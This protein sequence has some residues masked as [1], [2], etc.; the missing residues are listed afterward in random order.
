MVPG[1]RNELLSN[2]RVFVSEMQG[3]LVYVISSY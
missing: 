3:L 1:M 2:L